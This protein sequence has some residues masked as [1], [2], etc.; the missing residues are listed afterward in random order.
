M[1]VNLI[2][3]L[4]LKFPSLGERPESLMRRRPLPFRCQSGILK[5]EQEVKD[6]AS[7]SW[8]YYYQPEATRNPGIATRIKEATRGPGLT[9]RSKD[10]TSSKNATSSAR[11]P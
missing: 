6:A 3:P 2:E 8:P 7:S 1:I 9:T 5:Q 11:S 10:A 4:R